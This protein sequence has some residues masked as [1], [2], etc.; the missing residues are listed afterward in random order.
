MMKALV[1]VHRVGGRRLA[2]LV[3][4]G[5]LAL[6]AVNAAVAPPAVAAP[7]VVPFATGHILAA[8]HMAQ[9]PTTAE[10]EEDFGIACYQTFQLQRAYD[11]APLYFQGDR[12]PGR[13]DR[14]R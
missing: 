4:T 3:S 11:L 2:A 10:C 5:M 9:P 14:D 6:V 1:P 7:R 12:G 8:G 13:D